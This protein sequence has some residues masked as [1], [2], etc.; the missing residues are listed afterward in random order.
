MGT[1]ALSSRTVVGQQTPGRKV[2]GKEFE[3]W[4]EHFKGSSQWASDINSITS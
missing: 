2:L 3:G 1:C 4:V